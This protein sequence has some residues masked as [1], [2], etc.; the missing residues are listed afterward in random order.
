[1]RFDFRNGKIVRLQTE[2]TRRGNVST[3]RDATPAEI[4][5]IHDA[6]DRG[7]FQVEQR[8]IRGA[9]GVRQ[10]S[11]AGA[12]EKVFHQATG[13]PLP[14]FLGTKEGQ[15]WARRTHY[16]EE[17]PVQS[18]APETITKPE[19]SLNTALR[20]RAK[21]VA[22]SQRQEQSPEP[23]PVIFG[24]PGTYS[25]TIRIEARSGDPIY[26]DRVYLE[27]RKGSKEWSVRARDYETLPGEKFPAHL[28]Q[29][30]ASGLTLKQAKA[31]SQQRLQSG[32]TFD[33]TR[34]AY[35][36]NGKAV[37][38]PPR[39]QAAGSP[40][41]H[42]LA[43]VEAKP[44]RRP[45]QRGSFS[46]KPNKPPQQ[47]T[48]EEL[49]AAIGE[50]GAP[51]RPSSEKV[52][53][54]GDARERVKE[55]VDKFKGSMKA[56]GKAYTNPRS[57]I[58]LPASGKDVSDYERALGHWS[59]ADNRAAFLLYRFRKAAEEAVPS[60]AVR[61]AM[62][63]WIQAG[64]DDKLL[65][66]RAAD[67]RRG[68]KTHRYAKGYEDAQHL[69]QEEKHVAKDIIGYND[70]VLRQMQ[71]A[72][73][74]SEGVVN[75]VTQL[76]EKE[77]VI[78]N[79]VMAQ[80]NLDG[81]MTRPYF[82]NKRTFESYFDAE[83]A[84]FKPRNKDVFYLAAAH[85]RALQEAL[86]AREFVKRLK[87]G[88]ASDGRPL[89]I[90]SW[91]TARE[92][93]AE[94]EP[95]KALMISPNTSK[96]GEFAD[97]LP[98]DHPA[99]RGWRW[100]AEDSKGQ[101]IVVKG[102]VLVHPEIHRHLKNNLSK[103]G[104]S[105]FSF[106]AGGQVWKPGE[107]AL[108]I[109]AGLKH[110]IFMLSRFHETTLESHALEHRTNP[111]NLVDLD[112]QDPNQRAL[113]NGGLMV[114]HY[115]G[116][117]AFSEGLTGPNLR[118]VPGI[119]PFL[120]GYVDHL[121]KEKIPALAMNVGLHAL[122]RNRA[123]YAGQFTDAKIA[124]ITAKQMNAAFGTINYRLLG[125]NRTLQE[126]LRL[127]FMAPQF[128]EGRAKFVAQAFRPQG[129][130]QL[131][132]YL[133]G[134][135]GFLTLAQVANILVNGK[136]DWEDP[137]AAKIFGKIISMRSVQEDTWQALTETGRF[138]HNRLGPPASFLHD[139]IG[140]KNIFGGKQTLGQGA[141]EAARRNVPI[142]VQPWTRTSKATV[143]ERIAETILRAIGINIRNPRV[144]AAPAGRPPARDPAAAMRRR[145]KQLT[146]PPR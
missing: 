34:P 28:E 19:D 6:I 88:E 63:N 56:L 120:H 95:G 124:Q 20:N 79:K 138:L 77:P 128:L 112:M 37:T 141:L 55:A 115:E 122:E 97:Y 117:D 52:T 44:S 71:E 78:L 1:V 25:G 110:A 86:A 26:G 57:S 47:G 76:Y 75:Y 45:T 60:P 40:P 51:E 46:R 81:L 73:I 2:S 4:G 84:G 91:A 145:Q 31:L 14:E 59:G 7:Q 38:L 144:K 126:T 8:T 108:R 35:H 99:L 89:A 92:V 29:T 53:T 82:V 74:L 123:R 87:D 121:F 131:W 105:N 72:G 68:L 30:I 139:Y 22:E 24:K 18:P 135:A 83:Q 41:S 101:S 66:Q 136:P 54:V 11:D 61:E 3:Y 43:P 33:R 94:N 39:Q 143:E 49:S 27:K 100:A 67:S 90:T 36:P 106:E 48:I 42:S 116:M 118:N 96:E 109:N 134:A 98:L 125:R 142:P 65:A 10:F 69:T 137:F 5:E 23:G 9:L 129:R 15:D 13:R 140:S 132:A 50:H 107:R 127:L 62:T 17:P 80:A 12:L 16:R 111:W 70:R 58:L 32:E 102:D 146:R 133:L 85:D 119:G 93:P 104:I 103:G 21:V 64:G 130:E 114:A 113:I